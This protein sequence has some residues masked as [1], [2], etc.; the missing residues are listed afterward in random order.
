MARPCVQRLLPPAVND[1]LEVMSSVQRDMPHDPD[2]RPVR[3]L[4]QLLSAQGG[5]CAAQAWL[6]AYRA[7]LL[8]YPTRR[9]HLNG[10][11]DSHSVADVWVDGAWRLFDPSG[12]R[13]SEG[14]SL[15]VLRGAPTTVQPSGVPE[16][17]GRYYERPFL[18]SVQDF[19]VFNDPLSSV[20]FMDPWSAD[21]DRQCIEHANQPIVVAG[22]ILGI[23]RAVL[24][25]RRW[26][27]V[28]GGTDMAGLTRPQQ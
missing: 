16:W 10:N 1:L 15:D 24:L 4:K 11:R 19:L 26:P 22:D 21:P 8:G 18:N 28:I 2:A 12:S 9:V 20:Y 14:S 6:F 13:T 5:L 23:A 7:S 25:C 17:V 27:K 3:H